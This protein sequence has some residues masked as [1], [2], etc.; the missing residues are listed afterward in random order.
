MSVQSSRLT[1]SLSVVSQITMKLLLLFSHSDMSDSLWLHGLQ[2]TRLPCL[3]LS[4]RA[5]SN[6]CPLVPWCQPTISSFVTPFSSCLQFFPPAGSFPMGWLLASG[7]QSI[8]V[9]ASV[10]LVNI[11]DWFALELTSWIS[12][13][14]KGLSR[15]FS[16]T[17]AEKHQFSGIQPSLW[18]NSHIHT[19]LL[20]KP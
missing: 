8:E 3:S 20:E 13:L 4:P 9:S 15:V 1:L 5:C 19:R 11:Q 7:V 14:S 16:N 10:L 2:H 17:T 6:S 12:L 18:S